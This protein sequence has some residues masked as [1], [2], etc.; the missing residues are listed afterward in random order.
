M[1][2]QRKVIEVLVKNSYIVKNIY[3][4]PI[5]YNE[6]F[7]VKAFNKKE[8]LSKVYDDYGYDFHKKDFIVYTLEEFYSGEDVVVIH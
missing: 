5:S 2:I 7:L 1:A 6:W 8:A 3:E 4:L